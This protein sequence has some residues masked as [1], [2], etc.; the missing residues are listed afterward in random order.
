[1]DQFQSTGEVVDFLAIIA[2]QATVISFA[3]HWAT[4]MEHVLKA[5]VFVFDLTQLIH[6]TEFF[7]NE[8]TE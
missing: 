4:K 2:V 8:E 6:K 1:M 5:I 3:A 7:L